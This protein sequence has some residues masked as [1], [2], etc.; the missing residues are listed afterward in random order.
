M[1]NSSPDNYAIHPWLARLALVYGL[2]GCVMLSLAMPPFQNPDEP[3][4]FRRAEQV[5]GGH[6]LAERHSEIL[7]GPVSP[8][9]MTTADLFDPLRFHPNRHV[10]P[11]MTVKAASIGWGDPKVLTH[12]PNSAIYPAPFYLP[13]A[14]GVLVGKALALS[15]AT[16]LN[17]ARMLTGICCVLLSA[18]GIR[19]A[20]QS[21]QPNAAIWLFTLTTLPMT[22]ALQNAASQD[23]LLNASMLVAVALILRLDGGTRD[24]MRFWS[25]VLLLGLITMARPP[26][27]PLFV[28]P[29]AMPFQ[30]SVRRMTGAALIV[31]LCLVWTQIADPAH[32]ITGQSAG[33]DVLAQRQVIL[34]PLWDVM[35]VLR[36]LRTHAVFYFDS[37]VGLLGWLDT[38]LPRSFYRLAG[39]ILAI[40]LWLSTG[41]SRHD[42]V[43]RQAA[44]PLAMAG[45]VVLVFLSIY[46]TFSTV[47]SPTI[48]GVQGR[49]FIPVLML[50]SCFASPGG[51][52]GKFSGIAGWAVMLF[53]ALSLAVTLRSVLMR[54]HAVLSVTSY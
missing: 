14:A 13:A 43:W 54:Y 15:V 18:W 23:G 34:D 45:C 44:I 47:R 10:T 37:F 31:V 39:L 25:A 53:P 32:V 17:L 52:S 2:I 5:G 36:T 22:M 51:L 46:L 8:G 27:A 48:D 20:A 30:S 41:R 38:S 21:S 40:S 26:Y 29:L 6:L 28:V 50:L 11:E 19:M 49:Y 35:L 4:H 3:N 42:M 7:G 1:L 16:T 33:A 24:A 9:I 12:F